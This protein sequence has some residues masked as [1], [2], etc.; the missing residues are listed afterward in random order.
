MRIF[1]GKKLV[2]AQMRNSFRYFTRCA[3]TL[4]IKRAIFICFRVNNFFKSTKEIHVL[5]LFA[6]RKTY[7]SRGAV[8]PTPALAPS[9]AL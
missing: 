2:R 4:T 6:T 7:G 3:K 9:A 1:F 8:P 5:L